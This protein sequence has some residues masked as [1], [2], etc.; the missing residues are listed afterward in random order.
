MGWQDDPVIQPAGKKTKAAWDG[1]WFTAGD[2]GSLDDEGFLTLR[3][4]DGDLII[5]GGVNVYP[6][7]VEQAL[8]ELDGVFQAVVFGTP[9]ERWG[10]RVCAVIEGS[11]SAKEVDVFA[12]S[13]LAPYKRPKDIVV[14]QKLPRTHSGKVDRIAAQRIRI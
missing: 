3:G 2:L 13:R 12:R 9:D 8:L 4:R 11:V 1:E 6:A 14:R 10:Q 5:S 7:E